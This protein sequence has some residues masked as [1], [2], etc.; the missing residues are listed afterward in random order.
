M[1][2]YVVIKRGCYY[3]EL[4]GVFSTPELAIDAANTYASNDRDSHHSY[5]V[6]PFTLDQQKQQ[7][8]LDKG[9]GGPY[10]SGGNIDDTPHIYEVSKDS[11]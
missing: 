9:F 8:P 7:K 5:V 10:G 6:L 2:L 4:G 1:E 11:L 3:H